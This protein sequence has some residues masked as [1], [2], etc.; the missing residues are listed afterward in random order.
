MIKD[1]FKIDLNKK[2]QTNFE[3]SNISGFNKEVL[4]RI[5]NRRS[6]RSY[7]S[8]IPD[9]EIVYQII[10]AA[11]N[12]PVA[13]NIINYEVILVENKKRKIDLA[14][15]C[16]N[17][18]WI[19]E[20]PYVIV[21]LSNKDMLEYQYPKSYEKFAFI[22]SGAFIESIINLATIFKLNSCWVGAYDNEKVGGIIGA[23]PKHIVG[24]LTLGYS[25]EKLEEKEIDNYFTKFSF[26]TKGNFQRE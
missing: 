12:S 25:E 17:Q 16:E 19:N 22:N 11:F 13:G 7:S 1:I 3:S 4:K 10:E 23:D 26:E 21:V 9:F 18:I 15:A 24:V 14:R 20:A 2:N 5:N 6:V 8:K